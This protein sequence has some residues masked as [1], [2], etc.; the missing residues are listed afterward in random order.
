M[1]SHV[2][3]TVGAWDDDWQHSQ[4]QE[5]FH[6]KT[7]RVIVLDNH[8]VGVCA[9]ER[10]RDDYFVRLLEILPEYQHRGIGSTVLRRLLTRA[11]REACP[12]TLLAIKADGPRHFYE[13]LG[14]RV[15]GE[16]VT[17]YLMQAIPQ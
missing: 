8:D 16:T 12:V 6:P 10:R 14:F 7:C 9:Y 1:R 13:R 4:F 5:A 15:I 11:R 17:H 2:E 3:R